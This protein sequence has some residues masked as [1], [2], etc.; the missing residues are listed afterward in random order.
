[1]GLELCSYL[2]LKSLTNFAIGANSVV[3][4]PFLKT[5]TTRKAITLVRLVKDNAT[6]ST[7]LLEFSYSVYL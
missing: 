1:M 7:A 6:E 4:V 3:A 2:I 5:E